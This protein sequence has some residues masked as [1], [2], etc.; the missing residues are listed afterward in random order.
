MRDSQ[1]RKDIIESSLAVT[2]A[3]HNPRCEDV[4]FK[5]VAVRWTRKT[6]RAPLGSELAT[7]DASHPQ[8]HSDSELAHVSF[9]RHSTF[10]YTAF[11]KA[12]QIIY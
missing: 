2:C 3:L 11:S 1:R 10:A 5:R 12:Q 7:I 4:Y 8:F 6:S 9:D